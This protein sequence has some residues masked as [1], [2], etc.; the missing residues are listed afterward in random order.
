MKKLGQDVADFA[1]KKST[2]IATSAE[3]AE[4][5]SNLGRCP[6]KINTSS[7]TDDAASFIEPHPHDTDQKRFQF[8]SFIFYLR[9]EYEKYDDAR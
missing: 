2:K 1:T 8:V 3:S 5:V 9:R 6:K 4:N 7:T